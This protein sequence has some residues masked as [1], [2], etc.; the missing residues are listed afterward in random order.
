MADSSTT[1]GPIL[2]P[3]PGR[4]WAQRQLHAGIRDVAVASILMKSLH[5]LVGESWEGSEGMLAIPGLDGRFLHNRLTDFDSVTWTSLG[6]TPATHRYKVRLWRISI[7]R[8]RP[9]S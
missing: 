7:H 4:N 3:L 9:A 5:S 2:N 1:A 6:T 8:D